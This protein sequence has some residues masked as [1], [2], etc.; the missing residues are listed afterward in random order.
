MKMPV[1]TIRFF[2]CAVLVMF[3]AG[4]ADAQQSAAAA[5]QAR[6]DD[7]ARQAAREFAA[8]RT[9]PAADQTRPTVPTPPPGEMVNLTVDEA[10]ARALERNL[11]IAVERLNPQT[12]DLNIARIRASYRPITSSTIGQCRACSRRRAP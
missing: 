7:L 4:T 5:D 1:S 8:A 9:P 2:A 6:L 11:D 12:F 3:M 10:T